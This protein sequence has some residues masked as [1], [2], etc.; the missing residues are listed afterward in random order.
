M[1]LII[2][3]LERNDKKQRPVQ[4]LELPETFKMKHRDILMWKSLISQDDFD[5][6]S[7]SLPTT[8]L[9][10]DA[11]LA[12]RRANA[13]VKYASSRLKTREEAREQRKK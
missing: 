1:R 9:H 6:E 7:K 13:I 12:K 11:T 2:S 8:S 3:D 10:H 5:N 4:F